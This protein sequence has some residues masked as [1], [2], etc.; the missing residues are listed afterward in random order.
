MSRKTVVCVLFVFILAVAGSFSPIHAGS[1]SAGD[2]SPSVEDGGLAAN[3]MAVGSDADPDG[4]TATYP[5]ASGGGF[6]DFV[7]LF[8]QSLLM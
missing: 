4:L 6:L 5:T 8:L 7:R 3:P 1:W 2:V